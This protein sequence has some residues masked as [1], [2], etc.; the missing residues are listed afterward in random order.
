MAVLP[1][2]HSWPY[3][4]LMGDIYF[5]TCP[6]CGADNVLTNMKKRDLENAKE[7]I[8]TIVIAPCCHGKMTVLE[9]D[10]DYFWTEEKLR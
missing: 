1:F 6:F 9:A 5:H 7:G 10:D 8:K 3:E 2:G 4:R